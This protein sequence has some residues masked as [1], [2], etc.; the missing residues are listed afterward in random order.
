MTAWAAFHST[1]RFRRFGYSASTASYS[2]TAVLVVD[3]A[4]ANVFRY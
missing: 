4:A 2:S 1:A 3:C